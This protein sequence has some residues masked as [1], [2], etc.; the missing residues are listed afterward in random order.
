[1]STLKTILKWIFGV[2]F[3]LVG[4]G[5]SFKDF[6]AGIIFLLLGIFILPP[7]YELFEK[8]TKLIIPTWGKWT[9]VIVG[10]VLASFAVSGV[11]LEK[12]K[13]MDLIVAK[14]SEFINS[15]Q[16]DSANVYIQKA[17]K[18]YSSQSENKAIDLERELI[19]YNS[20][21]FVKETLVGMTDTEFEQ[22]QSDSLTKPYFTQS[23]LNKEFI[24][25]MKTQAPER[26]RIIKG[27]EEKKE[28]ERIAAKLDAE[29]KK[30]EELNKNN[31]YI[32]Y[33]H[34]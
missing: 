10:F 20:P 27:I 32:E 15:G 18:E 33:I 25:L 24:R 7:T 29:R 19:D 28:Q 31:I 3:L 23:T 26:Q 8:K 14:A 11:N 30:E 9:T 6:L 21:D 1:M 4:L 34:L 13:E 16:I 17:K 22:L 2:F 5:A 12:D